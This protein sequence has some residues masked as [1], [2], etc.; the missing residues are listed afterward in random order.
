MGCGGV[1]KYPYLCGEE[2]SSRISPGGMEFIHRILSFGIS[3]DT[4][5]TSINR[6]KAINAYY[7][8]LIPV[9]ILSIVVTL[10]LANKTLLLIN[11]GSLGIFLFFY[12]VFPPYKQL[13]TSGFLA[14]MTTGLMMLATYIFVPTISTDIMLAF[15]L[16]FPIGSTTI[17]A[18]KSLWLSI[19]LGILILILN[20]L[21]LVETFT[22][23]DP[24]N[25]SIFMLIYTGMILVSFIVERSQRK[26]LEKKVHTAEY[27]ESEIRQKDE[28]ISKLSHKLRTSLSNITLINNLV[29][30]SR[31]SSAQKELLDTLKTSTFD[32]I[33][34]VNELV[35]IATPGIIDFKQ[36]ILSFSLSNALDGTINILNSD[37][38]FSGQVSLEGVESLDYHV[39]GDPSLLRSI[40]INLIK[41]IADYKLIGEKMTLA[42][43]IDYESQNLYRLR[44]SLK[45]N[46]E[47]QTGLRLLLN[48]IHKKSEQR[49][50][51]LLNTNHLLALTAS[52]LEYS[53]EGSEPQVFFFQELSK[54]LTKKVE[55]AVETGIDEAPG[56]DIKKTLEDATLLLVED[57]NINQKIVLLSL[58]KLVKRIDVASNGKEALDMF[59]TKSYDMILMDIQMPVMDGIT[60]TKKIREIES[61]SEER[62]PIIAITANALAGDRDNCLAAGVDD[63]VSKPF[64]VD[65]VV[66]KITALLNK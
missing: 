24:L 52:S 57:N 64:Q 28:F 66:K 23:L 40:L 25:L 61:T 35:E 8:I 54:D 51:K 29:H 6:I 47:D 10:I 13:K 17:Q 16:L 49:I 38:S 14:M 21:P 56:K 26:L 30:D 32:L 44:F 5:A 12:L 1:G 48:N 34:D 45:F 55:A 58:N 15:F 31:M 60:A 19:S 27:Y 42:V 22:P 20:F 3:E 4:D 9:L 62:I 11:I 39:I 59:G 36:S 33:N 53:F 50:S 46:V 41:G 37:E 65:E 7:I 43:M 18:H 2:R 63:Y